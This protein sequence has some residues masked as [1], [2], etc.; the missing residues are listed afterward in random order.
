MSMTGLEAFDSTV[1]KTNRWLNELMEILEWRDKHKAYMAM[2]AA[3]HALRD[4]LTV[5][6]AAQL[7][8]QLPM[9][10]RGFYYEG[11]D[12]SNKPLKER[13]REQFYA[14]V[15][16]ELDAYDSRQVVTAVFTLLANRISE[17]EIED[18]KQ[19]LPSELRELWP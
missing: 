13:H 3:L 1:H 11:W 14:L 2:K 4:R 6:E 17:G 5:D 9:L 10:M 15:A 12:P 8:A 19:V 7:G 16:R 18:V